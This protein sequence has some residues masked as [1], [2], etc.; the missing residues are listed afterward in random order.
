M[1]KI[2]EGKIGLYGGIYVNEYLQTDYENIFAVGD[3]IEIE[4]IIIGTREIFPYGSLANRE[5]RVVA[6]NIVGI[7]TK[8]TGAVGSVSIKSF[9]TTFASTGLNSKALNFFN[10]PHRII[11]ATFYDKPHYF[12]GNE[13]IFAKMIY[14][15]STGKLFGIQLAGKGEVVRYVDV[16]AELLR[17]GA[18]IDDLTNIEHCYTPP[19]STPINPLNN[20]GYIAQNH[21]KYDIEQISPI[22]FNQFDGLILDVRT[23]EEVKQFPLERVSVHIPYEELRRNLDKLEKN[24]KILCVCQKGS[25][26]LES[27]ILLKNLAFNDVYYLGGG[28]QMLKIIF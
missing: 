19:H 3:C 2:W 5:G 9:E 12:P 26:S 20:L 28:I 6:N 22:E 10:I 17:N 16:F 7:P 21:K 4:N 25:R 8:F 23:K 13:V 24:Q 18:S 15:E 27:A 14:D 1:L 11:L